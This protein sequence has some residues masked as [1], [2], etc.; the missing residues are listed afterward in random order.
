MS[1]QNQELD[2]FVGGKYKHGFV[3]DIQSDTIPPGLDESV[4]RVISKKKQEPQFMLD[5]RLRAFAHWQTMA[6]PA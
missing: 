1:K 6:I 3:T 5:W 4:V 2:D